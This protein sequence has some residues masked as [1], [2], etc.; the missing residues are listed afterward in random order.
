MIENGKKRREQ[1]LT[2]HQEN[3][4]EEKEVPWWDNKPDPEASKEKLIDQINRIQL[5]RKKV[6]RLLLF[7]QATAIIYLTVNLILLYLSI[8]SLIVVYIAVYMIPISIVLMDYLLIVRDIK[9][10]AIGEN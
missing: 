1:G 2:Y 6:P 5:A 9:K 4:P 7:K 8:N 10:E 3:K